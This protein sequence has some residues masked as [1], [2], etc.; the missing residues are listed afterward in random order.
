MV[1]KVEK[2]EAE[3]KQQ[4]TPEQFKVTRKKGTERAFTGIYYDNKE[5]GVYRCVCCGNEL[6]TSE[7]KYDSGTGWPSF[8]EP[9]SENSVRYEQD[10]G[11]FM[12]RVEV[13]C[14]KCDAHLGHVFEDG[15]RPTGKRYCMNSAS[16]DF[17]K[18]D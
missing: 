3:W 1:E 9:V 14:A 17:Q 6:F 5:K 4:L 16:L 13:L 18:T 11:L 12:R 2:T 10:N 8:W 15:P 7:T